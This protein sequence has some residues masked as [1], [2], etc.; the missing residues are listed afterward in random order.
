MDIVKSKFE[1]VLLT[2]GVFGKLPPYNYQFSLI[3][4][5]LLT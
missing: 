1:P 5:K 2:S 3:I 4:Y